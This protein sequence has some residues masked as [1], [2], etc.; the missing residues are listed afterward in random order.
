MLRAKGYIPSKDGCYLLQHVMKR[1][2]LEPSEYMGK[3][4][5]VMIGLDL[6]T[7]KVKAEW[8]KLNI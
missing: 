7:E 4:Y 3:H 2:Y 1:T 6:N 8:K 5:L